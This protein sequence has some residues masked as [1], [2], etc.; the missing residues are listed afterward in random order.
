MK[1]NYARLFSALFMVLCLGTFAQTQMAIW[2]FATVSGASTSPINAT[3]DAV[4]GTPY[5]QQFY[6]TIDDNGK[7]GTAYTDVASI[8]HTAGSAIAWDDIKGSGIDAEL[9]MHLSTAGY[10]NIFLRFNYKSESA[11]GFDLSYSTDNGISWTTIF[12]QATISA[13]GFANWFSITNNFSAY[14]G[15]EDQANVIFK[16]SK[17]DDT[18]NNK[19][20]FDNIEFYGTAITY[21]AG[22]P[23]IRTYSTTTRF[24]HN[25]MN[26]GSA[27][28]VI[29]DPTDPGRT[30]GINFL[31]KDSDTPATSLNVTTSS[32]N[33]TVVPNAN[34]VVT[35]VNDSIRNV[36]ITPVAVGYTNI[37]I[38]V[39]DGANTDSYVLNYAASA[40][41]HDVPNTVYH[42]GVGDGSTSIDV[43]NNYLLAADDET[44]GLLLYHRD[45]SGYILN[46]FNMGAPMGL[47]EEGDFEASTRKGNRAYWMGSLGNSSSGNLKPSRNRFFATDISGTGSSAAASYVGNYDIRAS[48]INWGDANGY[49]FTASGADGMIPKQIGGLNVEGMC[50]GPNP[51]T[52][53]IAFRA[54]LVP[55]SNRTKALI[56]PVTNFETW[57]NNGSPSGSPTYGTPIELDLGGR[58]IRS[59]EQNV[60]GQFLIVAGSYDD[61]SNPALFEWDGNPA[62]QPVLLTADLTTLNPEGIV[63]FPSPF[64]N[65]STVEIMSDDGTHDWY[66]DGTECKLLNDANNKKFRT[67]KVATTGGTLSMCIGASI[68]DVTTSQPAIC[69][70]TGPVTLTIN[71]S[72]NSAT[73]WQV[74][75]GS[76]GTT[77]VG[78]TSTSTI[79]VN[80]SATTTYYIRGEGGCTTPGSCDQITVTV[81]ALPTVTN[82]LSAINAQCV[83]ISSVTLT[84]ATPSGGTYSGAGVTMG[85]FSPST[86]G[87]GMHSITYTYT[88]GNGCTNTASSNIMV[89][90][91]PTVTN[92]LSSVLAQCENAG[93]VSLTSGTPSGG[94][95]S[96][97]GVSGGSFSPSTAGAGSHTITY[98][99][100]DADGCTNS[101]SGS[102]QVN[103]LPT[104]TNDLSAIDTQCVSVNSVTLTGGT[105]SGGTYSG[106][107]VTGTSFSPSTAGIGTYSITY[108]YMDGN[109]CTNTAAFPVVVS[110]CVGLHT[111]KASVA[112]TLYPNPAKGVFTITY[113]QAQ[114]ASVKVIN[115]L[116]QVVKTVELNA[117]GET[118]N[119]S[120]LPAGLYYVQL[121]V[122]S[123]TTINKLIKE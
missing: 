51:T 97:T 102:I 78:S 96:G 48:I 75:A 25:N 92:D 52:L 112:A 82:D 95:Y 109:G 37:T 120:A 58:G 87:V 61:V 118:V 85:N 22:I 81:N 103:A 6:Q 4:Q 111:A 14:S 71:G 94:I 20:A 50:I 62:S 99:Y 113:P 88:D 104:V 21:P 98:S 86:A 123:T 101:A 53:Y 16:L 100:T 110:G 42:T 1:N 35:T 93:T 24:L 2:D 108:T 47:Q 76:C 60:N 67:A 66:N 41:A 32:S 77:N 56:C 115:A 40:A 91:L 46:A 65:G 43:G 26:S 57:F 7:G 23:S 116:G 105:P 63:T 8:A 31:L 49:N 5:L 29:S 30:R 33:T 79:S 39:S 17:L 28:G 45:S 83:N 54:P 107:G 59:I 13:D 74:Y 114:K 70:G 64:Y 27:S 90:G 106:T 68:T 89:N 73:A 69:A 55:V 15:M 84:G 72:L 3:S 122:G 18:G 12:I 36:K 10:E 38:N 117:S 80:P 119:V 34:V 121:E 44:N 19:F 9:H 11:T